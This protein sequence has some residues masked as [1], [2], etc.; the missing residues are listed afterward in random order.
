V[1]EARRIIGNDLLRTFFAVDLGDAARHAAA[2]LARELAEQAGGDAVRWV[3]PEAYHV[4]LRFLGSTPRE[5]IAALV[6]AVRGETAA[7]APFELRVGGLEGLPSRRR[8][9]VI[10]LDV[11]PREPLAELAAAVERG[12]VAAGF[13][14]EARAFRGHL[15]LG[16]VERPGAVRALRGSC[17]AAPF[18]VDS[19]ALFQSESGS[20][21][22]RLERIAL[23]GS[24]PDSP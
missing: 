10:A 12:V 18:P 19:L 17:E 5:R 22:T 9:R 1:R 16:R 13:A 2:A 7:L 14:P 24:R 23:V 20:R 6:A 3:R 15:T 11:E 8:P 21:Y 4:T